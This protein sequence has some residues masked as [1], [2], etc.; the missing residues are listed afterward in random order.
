LGVPQADILCALGP[1]LALGRPIIDM[2]G[3]FMDKFNFWQKWL[4]GLGLYLCFFGLVLC[5]FSNSSLMDFAFNNQIDPTFWDK[6]ELPDNAMRFRGWIYGVLGA[7]ISGWG[8][9]I[10]FIAHFPF[11]KKEKWAWD[12]LLSAAI[13]WFLSDTTISIYYEVGFNVIFNC[14]LFILVVLPLAFT[15]MHFQKQGSS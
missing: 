12:S 15:K 4:F 5:F 6:N 11:K 7:V 2:G 8:V 10:S 14:A 13:I 9:L 1:V 3:I